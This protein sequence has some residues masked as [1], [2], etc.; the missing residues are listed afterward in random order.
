MLPPLINIVVPLHNEEIVFDALV[1]RLIRL[2]TTSKLTIRVLLVDDGSTDNTSLLMRAISLEDERFTSIFLSRNFGHQIALTA[3]LAH[4]DAT[5]AVL[6]LDGDLQDPPELLEEFYLHF[7]KGF[8]VVYGIRTERKESYFKRIAYKTFYRI[9]KQV[10][11]VDIPLDAGDFSLLSRKVVNALNQMPEESRML[12]GMRSWVGF[13]QIGIPYKRLQRH[14]G[15]SKYNL[16]KLFQLAFN[17]IFNFSE[18]PIRFITI[19]GFSTM[20]LSVSY[21]IV[22]LFKKILLDTVP[23]GFTALIFLIILFGGVQLIAIG[24]IGEYILR[25]FFQVKKRP[26]YLI[27]TTI[28]NGEVNL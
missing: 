12:R 16:T 24:I 7:Q 4:V 3:G 9:L 15:N 19:L 2:M 1:Q 17:G 14:S 27:K 11:Y 18:Y 28:K 13:R 5:E 26:L 6:L 25:I 22:I 10:A 20:L 8:D 21:F 23:E